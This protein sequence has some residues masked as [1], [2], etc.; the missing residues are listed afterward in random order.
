MC[1][2]SVALTVG[3]VDDSAE[4]VECEGRNRVEDVVMNPATTV[5]IDLD[6]IGAVRELFAHRHART[7]DPIHRLYANR[8]R[9][10][11]GIGWLQRISACYVHG[12]PHHLHARSPDQ[13]AVNR[14]A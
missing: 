8:Y 5:G 4:L 7:L 9:D 14:I 12:T 11:P 3:F 13:P 1:C 6:P 2:Y 10:I